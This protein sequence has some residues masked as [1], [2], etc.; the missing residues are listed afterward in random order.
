MGKVPTVGGV[1]FETRSYNKSGNSDTVIAAPPIM[2][3][4]GGNE[5]TAA[6]EDAD[7]ADEDLVTQEYTEEYP[8]GCRVGDLFVK[9]SR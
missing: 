6:A 8:P 5:E 1:A 9:D 2:L 3:G 4:G 7:D